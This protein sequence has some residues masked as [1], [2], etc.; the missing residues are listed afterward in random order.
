MI[1]CKVYTTNVYTSQ[2]QRTPLHKASYRG[3][4]TIVQLLLEAKA[5]VNARDKVS[6]VL[7]DCVKVGTMSSIMPIIVVG[8]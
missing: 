3:H 7:C 4:T 5:D 2:W 8:C 6:I 1:K